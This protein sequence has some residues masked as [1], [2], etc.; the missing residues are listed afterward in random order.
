[1]LY[2]NELRLLVRD[3]RGLLLVVSGLMLTL[4][5]AASGSWIAGAE[6]HAHGHAVEHAR[7]SWLEREPDN[8]HGRAH[9]GDYAFR[10]IGPLAGL[11]PGVQSVTGRALFLEAHSQNAPMHVPEA[12]ASSLMRFPR[13]NPAL[14]LQAMVP[15]L[16][17]LAGFASVAGER[18]SGRLRLLLVQGATPN[19]LAVAKVLA[20]W[21]VGALLS[22]AAVGVHGIANGAA[23]PSRLALFLGLHLGL[24]WIVAVGVVWISSRARTAGSAATLGIGVWVLGALVLPRLTA[25]LG[26]ETTPLPSRDAFEA[27]MRAA[28]SEG[29]DG[30]DPRDERRAELEASILAEYGVDSVEELPINIDGVVMQADEEYGNRV[31]D[32]HYGRLEDRLAQQL[33]WVGMASALNPF[34]AVHSVSMSVAGT[35]LKS[36][37]AFRHAAEAHRRGMVEALNHEHAYGGS[38]SG[39]W[40]SAP[41]AD[42]YRGFESFEFTPLELRSQLGARPWELAGIL[43]W[44]IAS[45]VALRDAARR[46]GVEARS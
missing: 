1:M 3:G 45:A 31:W 6:R 10:P 43:A 9:F 11:D 18:E 37:L 29:L 46:I 33:R 36:E 17:I 30:H 32:D 15:L 39:D 16:M 34:H 24:A 2:L 25:Q 14:V 13:L 21:T 19:Q 35:D 41:D 5:S 27:E 7:E 8:P 28:R 38:K 44:L 40:S 42:F 20:I 23:E 12:A 4:A 26:A 22:F